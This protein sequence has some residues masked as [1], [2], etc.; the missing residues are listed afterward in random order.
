MSSQEDREKRRQK[1]DFD[2]NK[3]KGERGRVKN[4]PYNRREQDQ[5]RKAA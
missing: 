4:V 5:Q 3:G 1:L 2:K